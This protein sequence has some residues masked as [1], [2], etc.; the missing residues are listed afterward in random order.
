MTLLKCCSAHI[1]PLV[2]FFFKSEFL[3][4]ECW[5]FSIKHETMSD[6][7]FPCA[8]TWKNHRYNAIGVS[9]NRFGC[10]AIN[11]T[12]TMD[13]QNKRQRKKKTSKIRQKLIF[14]NGGSEQRKLQTQ[15]LTSM[16]QKR[17]K[18][19]HRGEKALRSTP[20]SHSSPQNNTTFL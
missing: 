5:N 20:L 16:E 3:R 1:D 10:Q 12:M 14:S 19:E 13:K 7:Y 9:H 17:K 8:I 18:K 6:K 2:L 15:Q 4:F 11:H